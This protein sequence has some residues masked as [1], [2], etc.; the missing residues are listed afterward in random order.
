M[1]EAM[2][3]SQAIAEDM[4][5]ELVIHIRDSYGHHTVAAMVIFQH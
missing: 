5:T 3:G 1:E 2:S 4:M